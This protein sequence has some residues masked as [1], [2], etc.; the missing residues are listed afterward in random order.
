MQAVEARLPVA[1]VD[2]ARLLALDGL[3]LLDAQ[4][5]ALR[6]QLAELRRRDP[7]SL[8]QRC[9]ATEST[10]YTLM[11]PWPSSS[12]STSIMWKRST[13]L[14]STSHGQWQCSEVTCESGQGLAKSIGSR[15]PRS[16]G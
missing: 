13:S 16:A 2:A 15:P 4:G 12:A 11:R 7:S 14:A 9:A 3:V 6:E 1:L 8:S 10:E 5:L